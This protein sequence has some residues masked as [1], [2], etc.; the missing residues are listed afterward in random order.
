MTN[1]KTLKHIADQEVN[2]V[3]AA[4]PEPIRRK[5]D[6]VLLVIQRQPDPDLIQQ[7]LDPDLLG[8]FDGDSLLD[9]ESDTLPLPPTI[10]LY[11]DNLWSEAGQD[12]ATY[13]REVRV[14]YLHEIGHY[15]GLEEDA[16]LLR[17]PYMELD[18]PSNRARTP[19]ASSADE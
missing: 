6:D 10:Y 5:L 13:R 12:E 11:T 4:L 9:Q 14:T 19:W 17:E 2:R 3:H 18:Q 15:L 8:L 16:V 1:W 7:G